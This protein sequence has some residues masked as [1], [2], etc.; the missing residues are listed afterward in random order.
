MPGRTVP[1]GP[2][3]GSTVGDLVGTSPRVRGGK[4]SLTVVF[5]AAV[6]VGVVL[7]GAV[8]EGTEVVTFGADRETAFVPARDEGGVTRPRVSVLVPVM[9]GPSV[10]ALS[11]PS[12]PSLATVLR[13]AA[14]LA[15]SR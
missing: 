13:E 12:P 7:P 6:I 9:R 11:S 2:R 14:V 5:A 4:L 1:P 8:R 15:L 3:V 10:D